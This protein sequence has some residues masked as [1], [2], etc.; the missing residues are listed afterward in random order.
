MSRLF[1][2]LTSATQIL[3]AVVLLIAQKPLMTTTTS[4]TV[5]FLG[6]RGAAAAYLTSAVC[7]LYATEC[8]P[9]KWVSVG[10]MVP[11]FVLCTIGAG[12]IAWTVWSGKYADGTE[13]GA[14]FILNDQIRLWLWAVL[15]CAAT[16]RFLFLEPGKRGY[17]RR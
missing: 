2:C 3:Y 7:S 14:M 16:M 4:T 12:T 6:W 1:L 17:H 11:Q 15:N 13:R 5:G 9:G 8:R 10:L